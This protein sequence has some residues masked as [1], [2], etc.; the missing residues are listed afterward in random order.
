MILFVGFGRLTK[1]LL[2]LKEN[3]ANIHVFHKKVRTKDDYEQFNVKF[4]QPTEFSEVT[5]V[6]LSLPATAYPNFFTEYGSY[7]QKETIFFHMATGLLK[8]DVEPYIKGCKIVP[9]KCIGQADQMVVD[10]KAML[11]VPKPFEEERKWLQSFFSKGISVLEGK[12][13]DVLL[14]NQLATKKALDLAVSLKTEL[15]N[16]GFDEKWI[17]HSL[18]V[19]VRGVIK[20]YCHKQLG[21]FGRKLLEEI[22]KQNEVSLD[23]NR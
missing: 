1:S 21:G 12:E 8:A 15:Q 20:S 17:D 2:S 16:K 14:I 23:E 4:L 9:C 5:H 19:T 13:E 10:Q 22:E 3:E 6:F 7:F 11:I 18:E